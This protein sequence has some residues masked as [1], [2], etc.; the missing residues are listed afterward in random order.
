MTLLRITFLLLMSF[1]SAVAAEPSRPDIVGHRGLLHHA[2]EN[3]LAN[4]R[5]CLELRF[6]FE[7]DV[8]R[9][10]DGVLMCLH[11]ATVDRTTDGRGEI[12][13][14]SFAQVRRLDAGSWFGV[15][16][17]GERVPTVKEVIK[18]ISEY[19]QFDVLVAVDLKADHVA[20]DVVRMA[21]EYGILDKLLFIGAAISDQD[22]RAQIREASAEANAAAVANTSDEFAEALAASDAEWV[23]FRFLPSKEQMSSVRGSAKRAFIAGATVAGNLPHNWRRTAEL[24]IDAVLTDYPF[25]MRA[26]LSGQ[27]SGQ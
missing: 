9:T 8:R 27:E 24:E 18:L 25:E 4:F 12:S 16:F 14:L 3:T 10:K 7:F 21:K 2:P 11:D 5:A 6:G 20:A 19:R 23:Y 13:E 15:E 1:A 26:A 17:K 22:V